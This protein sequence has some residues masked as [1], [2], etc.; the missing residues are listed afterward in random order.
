[1]VWS[2]VLIGVAVGGAFAY[3][4]GVAIGG[5][6]AYTIGL[7]QGRRQTRLAAV[8]YPT[9]SSAYSS[10]SSSN[11]SISLSTESLSTDQET[12]GAIND[13]SLAK[14][15][16]P[17]DQP[18]L[19]SMQSE[20][21]AE[22]NIKGEDFERKLDDSNSS[23]LEAW[24]LAYYRSVQAEQFKSGFLAR[25]A[26]ELRSP[27]SS[28]VG[29]HQ[30]ILSDLCEDREEER[31]FIQQANE[32]ILKWVAL[33]DH[34]IDV[35]KVTYSDVTVNLQTISTDK[36]FAE[37]TRLIELQAVN[38]NLQISIISPEETCLGIGD[39]KRLCQAL[40]DLIEA[41]ITLLTEQGQGGAL[42]LSARQSKTHLMIYL[43][44]T[45]S[46]ECWQEPIKLLE[47]SDPLAAVT[48][49]NPSRD[50]LLAVIAPPP[51]T[52]PTFA[53]RLA[54]LLVNSMG[55]VL[56][57]RDLSNEGLSE[58]DS[59]LSRFEIALPTNLP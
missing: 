3:A 43:D 45:C 17:S 42:R 12:G 1:M 57:I 48:A 52:S 49:P 4:I 50:N 34:L 32:A 36:I 20:N 35:S 16:Q 23:D 59:F 8:K 7:R 6:I 9:L 19:N 53:L 39:P 25:T 18:Y 33:L 54:Q 37:V 55:G 27:L 21:S 22:N 58:G 47:K 40:V 10:V 11:A 56:T 2:S 31:E 41:L 28:A 14:D 13:S 15:I 44:S 24:R 51:F 29:L 26:H 46:F 30:L 5:A 38:R